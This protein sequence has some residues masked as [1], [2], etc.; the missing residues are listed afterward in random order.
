MLTM[1]ESA[2][3]TS[4]TEAAVPK[5]LYQSVMCV[6]RYAGGPP[7]TSRWS[8]HMNCPK[9]KFDDIAMEKKIMRTMQ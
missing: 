4:A 5:V 6:A 7:G 9:M 3:N 1:R 8:I 2:V